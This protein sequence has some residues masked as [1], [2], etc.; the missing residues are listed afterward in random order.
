M[1][2]EYLSG[3]EVQFNST[4]PTSESI[5]SWSFFADWL[6]QWFCFASGTPCFLLVATLISYMKFSSQRGSAWMCYTQT[7]LSPD[8]A[9]RFHMFWAYVVY[10]VMQGYIIIN[11]GIHVYWWVYGSIADSCSFCL[12][13]AWDQSDA[14]VKIY[15]TDLS[16]VSKLPPEN[17]VCQ[18]NPM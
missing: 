2:A 17:V 18:F 12:F 7:H 4:Y 1:L 15:A 9:I 11:F 6:H 14:F 8:I 10:K 16:G 5:W 13:I 3:L